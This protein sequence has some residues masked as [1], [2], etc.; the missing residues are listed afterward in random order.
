[1]ALDTEEKARYLMFKGAL[2]DT[3]VDVRAQIE[4]MS[5][6]LLAII[7]EDT[8]VGGPALTLA[9]FKALEKG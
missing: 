8:N 3:P 9:M 5:E 7:N 2:G 4:S 6:R 1:M